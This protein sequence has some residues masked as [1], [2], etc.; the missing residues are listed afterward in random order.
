MYVTIFIKFHSSFP[1]LHNRETLTLIFKIKPTKGLFLLTNRKRDARNLILSYGSCLR[2]GLIPNLL[3]EGRGARYNARDAV[4]WWLKAIADYCQIYDTDLLSQSLYRLYPTDDSPYPNDYDLSHKSTGP[5]KQKLF[6]V[7]QEAL[8]THVNGLKFRERHAGPSIDEHMS[9]EGFNIEI[10]VDLN[11]GFVFGGNAHNCGT[12][13]DKMG[14]SSKAGTRGEPAT[15]RDGSAVELV[16]LTRFV[17][18]FLTKC[19]KYPYKGVRLDKEKREFTWREW[20]EKIDA[21]FEKH[22]WID[23]D[24][25]ESTHINKVSS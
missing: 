20:A 17:L 16:G 6:D 12:W 21:N 10:G 13:C 9:E 3:C 15:P 2:H 14:S 25:C 19:A 5:N 1:I 22:F 24:S 18:E 23:E 8:S 11:T 7:M 4:W